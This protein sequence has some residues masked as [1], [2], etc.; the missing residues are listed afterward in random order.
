[1]WKI[2]LVKKYIFYKFVFY[3]Y[4]ELYQFFKSDVIYSFI[5]SINIDNI[6]VMIQRNGI[7]TITYLH[8]NLYL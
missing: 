8:E 3:R 2:P 1:M 7:I 5:N 4:G 6:H